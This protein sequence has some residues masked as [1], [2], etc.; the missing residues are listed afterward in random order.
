MVIAFKYRDVKVEIDL[1][2]LRWPVGV[3]QEVRKRQRGAIRRL[4]SNYNESEERKECFASDW[5][6]LE[7]LLRKYR[8]V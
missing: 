1:Q 3:K 5:L 7:T 8:T 6:K 4:V 2:K